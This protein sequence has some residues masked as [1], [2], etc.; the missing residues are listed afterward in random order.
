VRHPNIL[1]PNGDYL[2]NFKHTVQQLPENTLTTRLSFFRQY[3]Q[4]ETFAK[5]SA[6]GFVVVAALQIV[7]LENLRHAHCI[8]SC[9]NSAK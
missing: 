8:K 3:G 4:L 1:D 2:P 6:Y 5:V 9:L 7:L